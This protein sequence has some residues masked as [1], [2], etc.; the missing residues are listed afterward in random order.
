MKFATMIPQNLNDGSPVH[1]IKLE[2][3][4]RLFWSEYGG[5]T[6]DAVADGYWY[7]EGKLYKD[8]VRRVTVV[9]QSNSAATLD[10]ARLL[11]RRIGKIL[12]QESMYFEHDANGVMQ[13]EFLTIDPEKA[14]VGLE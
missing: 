12:G 1:S 11:V 6:V 5:C 10:Y 14:Y 13:V 7:N 9:T 4:Y 3:F 2:A 8:K